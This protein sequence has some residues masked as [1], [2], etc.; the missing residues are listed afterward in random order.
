[1]SITIDLPPAMAQEARDY[2]IVQGTTLE[3]MLLDYLGKELRRRHETVEVMAK[4]DA[5]ARKTSARLTGEA[6]KFN[7]ADAYP[8][9]EFA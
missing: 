2:A 7:R 8:D 9:G 1:M 4:L 6:Y 3:R 5:L